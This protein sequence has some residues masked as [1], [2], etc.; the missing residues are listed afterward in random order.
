MQFCLGFGN[1]LFAFF[2]NFDSSLLIFAF[3]FDF[4]PT[5]KS[6]QHS[7]GVMGTERYRDFLVETES[8]FECSFGQ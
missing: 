1:L 8:I 2:L 4:H 5:A 7:R 6:Y 3:A